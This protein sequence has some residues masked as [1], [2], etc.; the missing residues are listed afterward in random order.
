M[1]GSLQ[2]QLRAISENTN[3]LKEGIRMH[4]QQ[5]SQAHSN[6]ADATK[7]SPAQKPLAQDLFETGDY[8]D[9]AET[10]MKD[11]T[12]RFAQGRD[13]LTTSKIRNI[14]SMISEIYNEV[15]LSEE[16]ELPSGI[17]ERIQYLRIRLAY[18][19]GRENTVKAFVNQMKLLDYIKGIGGSRT[20]FLRFANY[21]EALV[22]Y[23]RYYGG[24]D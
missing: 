1:K 9:L 7:T 22:A 17:V 8:V 18:E 6:H 3:D 14:L 5:R 19:S 23:H 16:E 2:D 10:R 13:S 15:K 12:E 4:D 11:F 24:R 20:R 21:M